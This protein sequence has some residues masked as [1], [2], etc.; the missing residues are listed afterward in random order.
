MK[1][2]R[3]LMILI[4]LAVVKNLHADEECFC[5]DQTSSTESFWETIGLSELVEKITGPQGP[6]GSQGLP[7]SQGEVGPTGP[8]GY[9]GETGPTGP[10]GP[11]GV[12]GEAGPIGPQGYR[13]EIGPTGP[14]SP[15]SPVFGS[16]YSTTTQVLPPNTTIILENIGPMTQPIDLSMAPL[17][18]TI[19]VNQS[20]TYRIS[21][22]IHSM[23]TSLMLPLPPTMGFALY[24]N[25]AH[26]PSTVCANC[27][28]VPD[29]ACS[30]ISMDAILTLSSGDILELRNVSTQSTTILSSLSDIS[31]PVVS[32]AIDIFLLDLF[33]N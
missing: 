23:I 5:F 12:Q 19:T 2:F 3:F 16:A 27:S 33:R 8:Q 26:I 15:F 18:G 28:V 7:G 4:S 31:V 20:G 29:D 11:R 14:Y 22:R 10:Q 6:T 32:A 9:R 17:N 1:E 30:H 21:Y 13:G 25:G 24:L